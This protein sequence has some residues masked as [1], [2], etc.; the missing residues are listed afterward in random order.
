MSQPL[1][2]QRLWDLVRYMRSELLDAKL[3]TR[4]EFAALLNYETA[5]AP[6]QGSPSPRRLES[7]DAMRKRLVGLMQEL[8]QWRGYAGLLESHGMTVP[9]RVE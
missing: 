9:A 8:E 1:T 3:I 4:E 5:D 2:D 6:G 7:Y